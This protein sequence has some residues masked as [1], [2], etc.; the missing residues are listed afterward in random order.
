MAKR[1]IDTL[2]ESICNEYKV[3]VLVDTSFIKDYGECYPDSGQI[4]LCS[5]YS[6]NKIKIAVF[7]HEL[8][9]ILTMRRHGARYIAAS[10]FQEEFAVWSLTQELHLQYLNRPFS[11]EQADFM[12]RCLKTYSQHH[13]SFK[14]KYNKKIVKNLKSYFSRKVF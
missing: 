11:K 3:K 9:H 5:K 14:K 6:S 2:I 8:A 10:I 4:M 7:L 1:K 13:Y 12:L